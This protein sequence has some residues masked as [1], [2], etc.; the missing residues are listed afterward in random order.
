M[1]NMK[2]NETIAKLTGQDKSVHE[3]LYQLHQSDSA[4]FQIIGERGSGKRTLCDRVAE[5]WQAQT[6][7]IVIKL[8]PPL[9]SI[10]DD[11][12]IFKNFVVQENAQTKR[13]INIFQETLKEI[14]YIGNSFSAIVREIISFQHNKEKMEGTLSEN[15]QYVISKIKKICQKRKLLLICSELDEWDL[16]SKNLILNLMEHEILLGGE[17]TYFI[18]TTKVSNNFELVNAEK[19]YLHNITD[20]HISETVHFFNPKL[21]LDKKTIAEFGDLT[22][23]NLELIEELANM[24]SVPQSFLPTNY[25]QII[26]KYLENHSSNADELMQLLKEMAFIGFATDIRLIKLFS[27]IATKPFDDVL[28]EAI[29]LSY[30]SKDAYVISF[31]KR[32]VFTILEKNKYKDVHYYINL[33]KC[34]NRLYPTRYDLQMQYAWHGNLHYEAENLCLLYLIKYYRENNVFYPLSSNEKEQLQKN[35]NYLFYS[36]LCDAYKAYKCKDYSS[37]EQILLKLYSVSKEFRFEKDYLLSLIV[38][39]KYFSVDEFNERIDVLNSYISEN[40]EK[41]YPEMYL[42]ALMMLAEFYSEVSNQELL[43]NCIRKIGEFFSKYSLTDKQIQRYEHCFKLKANAFYKIEI[44]T[45][46]TQTAYEYFKN[47]ENMQYHTSDYYLALL[48]HA[49]NLIVLS[50]NTDAQKLLEDACQIIHLNPFLEQIHKDILINNLLINEYYIGN[51]PVDECI[52]AYKELV[53]YNLDCADNLLVKN[54]YIVFV[55]LNGHFLSALQLSEELYVQIK[56]ND[57]A[58]DYYR[59]YIL[60]NHCILLW[61]NGKKEDA[62][63]IWAVAKSLV[64]WP[65]DQ[66]YFKA[67]TTFIS[68][69]LDTISPNELLKEANWNTYL[70]LKNSNVVGEA[71]KFWSNLLLLSE[72]QIWSDY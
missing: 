19:K 16:K 23:G 40:F 6:Q 64:P 46:Y 50:K 13:F 1:L 71:W 27:Q 38:T 52:S 55:A 25:M 26:Q 70:F 51:C 3:I 53:E 8:I 7:G 61:L 36:E 56:Y 62:K 72:L 14:P 58:D 67:R 44:A 69:L 5:L 68:E 48:N 12:S 59:Y 30:L 43:R 20:E 18:A 29:E 54:N 9:Q 28:A 63:N 42:R 45:R 15:E 10:P 11:Y 22:N 57:D 41:D 4:I 47:P 37:A 65:Q 39:N 24:Y 31:V 21:Q 66:A 17:A 33:C 60:N 2:Y 35:N 49:A 32:Y 34:I